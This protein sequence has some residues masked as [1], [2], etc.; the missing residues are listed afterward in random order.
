ML[1]RLTEVK[2]NSLREVFVNPERV[3]MILEDHR[4]K[5]LNESGLLAEGLDKNHRFSRLVMDGNSDVIVVGSPAMIEEA[6]QRSGK[7]LLRG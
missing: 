3:V 6:L 5:S 1:I 4:T 2:N 7:Q